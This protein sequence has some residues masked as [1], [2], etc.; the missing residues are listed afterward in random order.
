MS[1]KLHGT[2]NY[3]EWSSHLLARFTSFDLLPVLEAK[4]TTLIY[5]NPDTPHPQSE[6]DAAIAFQR[7]NAHA[8][9]LIVE[10]LSDDIYA[11][12]FQADQFDP[13]N[14]N[15]GSDILTSAKALWDS[16]KDRYQEPDVVSTYFT[17]FDTLSKPYNRATTPLE[18]YLQ[19]FV[20][21]MTRLNNL[22]SSH[23]LDPI[24]EWCQTTMLV[25]SLEGAAE[26]GK[27]RG[28]M[29]EA[30]KDAKMKSIGKLRMRDLADDC[31]EGSA[32]AKELEMRR[33]KEGRGVKNEEVG[34]KDTAK[35]PKR[36]G[37]KA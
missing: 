34:E 20:R 2:T 12:V 8:R 5:P 27:G 35:A 10:S 7:K 22:A 33:G 29:Y 26:E 14:A 25:A 11:A 19:T 23:G 18:V 21:T 31:V 15:T 9:K 1:I 32:W 37:G 4:V 17:Y 6:I 24:P 30:F 16:L 28:Q 36:V 3:S 13:S